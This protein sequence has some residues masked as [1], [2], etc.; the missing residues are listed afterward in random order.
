M[1][2]L[3][4]AI[5]S[6]R[7]TRDLLTATSSTARLIGEQFFNEHPYTTASDFDGYFGPWNAADRLDS[8]IDGAAGYRLYGRYSGAIDCWLFA[9]CTPVGVTV[10]PLTTLWLNTDNNTATGYQVFGFASG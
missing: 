1:I 2:V 5:G 9:I 6:P 3:N 4:R 10:D 8:A 7:F